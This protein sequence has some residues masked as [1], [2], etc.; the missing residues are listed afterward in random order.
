[1]RSCWRRRGR[2]WT[3]RAWPRWPREMYER[4]RP[5]LPDEDPGRAFEDRAVRLVTTFG[6]AGVL[7]GDLTPEC[8]A[9]VGRGA[10]RAGRPGRGRGLPDA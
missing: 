5:D 10:G 7:T 3:C 2:G 1:M 6:G 9:V 8:A 4:S